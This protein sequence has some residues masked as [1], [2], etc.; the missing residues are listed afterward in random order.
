MAYFQASVLVEHMIDEYGESTIHQMLRAYGDGLDTEAALE[1]V[2]LDFDTLQASFDTAVEARFG[3][4]RRAMQGPDERTLDVQPSERLATLRELVEEYPGSFPVQLSLGHAL[5]A[6]G[7]TDAARAAFETAVTLAPM[8]TGA[9]S[10]HLPLASIA[11]EQEDQGVAMDHL[12]AHLEHDSSRHR[13]RAAAGGAGRGGGRRGADATRLR[14][15]RRD[16]PVRFDSS[17]SARAFGD[18]A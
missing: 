12:E 7:E 6:A 3:D 15:D 11:I 8:A 2:G 10:P 1:R 4:L 14:V 9:S 18:G 5:R 13:G 16:R 17:P